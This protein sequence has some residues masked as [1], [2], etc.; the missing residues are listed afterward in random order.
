MLL[1]LLCGFSFNFESVYADDQ[2]EEVQAIRETLLKVTRFARRKEN[3][4]ATKL[5]EQA[6][7]SLEAWKA[8][9][10]VDANDRTYKGLVNLIQ[11]RQE[12]LTKTEEKAEEENI[13]ARINRNSK[14]SFARHIMPILAQN[15]FDCHGEQAAGGLRMDTLDGLRAGG[16]SG[17]ILVP[18]NPRNSL[19]MQS[20]IAAG[21]KRM[22]K[23]NDPLTRD[24]L[25]NLNDWIIQGAEID[26]FEVEE[27]KSDKKSSEKIEIARPTGSETVSFTGDIAPFLVRLCLGCH[28]DQ[29]TR[30]GLSMVTFEKLLEG[31]ESGEVLLPG[32][33]ENS[34][35]FR[36]TGGLELPRMPNNDS[37]LNRK[38]YEDLKK[39]IEEGIKFDGKDPSAPLTSLVTSDE[40]LTQQ[41]FA[42]MSD[43]EFR[44]FRR[45]E[46]L[47]L[48]KKVASGDEPLVAET[49]HF[50][51]VGNVKED[52]LKE[53]GAM[54]EKNL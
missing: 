35:L 9:Y 48:W 51:L 45:E 10:N 28:N 54:A 4:E 16:K 39:W 25:I 14:V 34:R 37:R 17:K 52:R 47:Q 26:R 22:P 49:E 31:G 5:L 2:K 50:L 11:K 12:Q 1:L 6:S 27:E 21:D 30:G 19:I 3:E 53:A 38:N 44:Q 46:S 29:Q 13:P 41:K 33:L 42:K 24:Q 8:K 20:L 36:L 23:D 18:G 32:D 40:V 43:E 15:C 7:Q